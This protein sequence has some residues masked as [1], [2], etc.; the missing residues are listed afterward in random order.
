MNKIMK[1]VFIWFCVLT[2]AASIMGVLFLLDLP[3]YMSLICVGLI[4][5]FGY[6]TITELKQRKNEEVIEG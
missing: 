2:A 5:F 4:L 6:D 3:L 1:L